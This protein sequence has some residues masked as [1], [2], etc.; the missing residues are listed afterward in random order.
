MDA[1]KLG[2]YSSSHR[3]KLGVYSS[4]HRA[5]LEVYS[6]SHRTSPTF[7]VLNLEWYSEQEMVRW[8]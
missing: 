2:V 1:G 8:Y 4:S 3:A 5:K 6:S 7:P